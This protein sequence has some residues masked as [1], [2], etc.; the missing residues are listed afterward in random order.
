MAVEDGAVTR[1]AG[2]KILLRL[3][4]LRDVLDG[5]DHEPQSPLQGVRG[6][7]PSSV[8]PTRFPVGPPDDSVFAVEPLVPGDYLIEKVA[9]HGVAVVGMYKSKPRRHVSRV[10]PVDAE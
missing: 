6:S 8:Y 4:L 2:Q 7:S 3:L 10:A 9:A 1:F 5:P